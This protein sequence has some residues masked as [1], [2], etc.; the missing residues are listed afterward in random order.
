MK[1]HLRNIP[2]RRDFIATGA[3]VL[4]FNI[5]PRH[6]LGAP[7]APPPSE[8]LN[9]GCVGIGGQGGGVT[10]DLATFANVHIAAL[11]DVERKHE[12][13]MAKA[14]PGRPFYTD[15]REML[16]AEK[17][18]DAVMVGTP[19]HWH[20][21]ISIAAMKLGKHVYCEKPLAHTIEETRIMA[22]VAAETKVVT[23]MGNTGHASEGLRLTKEWIDAGAI[24][25]IGEVHVWS[26][27]PG[28]YWDS[29]GRARPTEKLPVPDTL[30]WNQWQGAA[31]EHDY[32]PLYVPRKWRG[33]YDYGCGALGDMMVHNADP[34]W[35]ALDLGAPIAVEA[36]TSATN[37]DS[38]P[39]WSVVTWHF[40]A[41][42]GRGPVRLTWH[43][44]G[45]RPA[46][47]PGF[48]PARKIGDNGILFLG[49]KGSIIAP[50]WCGTPRIVPESQMRSFKLPP[51]SLARSPGHREEW[52]VA[53]LAGKPEDAKANFAYAAPYTEALLTGVLPIRL[54]KRIDWDSAAMKAVNAPEADALIRKSYR[55]GFELPV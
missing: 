46:P 55:K 6:V 48:D 3:A 54:G 43:D 32:H 2:T 50:G 52:V 36:Q 47:P 38:F 20:A 8:K 29:Q 12:A 40:A 33:W 7:G 10:R 31:P 26:D 23:Q 42:A 13:T 39:L 19:D 44:G 37:A 27:R 49:D 18:L 24:G 16:S 28:T 41:K 22:R 45:K 14:Y 35:F 25:E 53:C 4:G 11:C 9:I 1:K 15:Y 17:G 51:R 21:P 30:D 5:I 34:A